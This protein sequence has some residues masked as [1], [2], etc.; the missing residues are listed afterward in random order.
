MVP[1]P[2]I[3][4]FS[5]VTIPSPV[6]QMAPFALDRD[7]RGVPGTTWSLLTSLPAFGFSWISSQWDGHGSRSPERL[8]GLSSLALPQ[9]AL[10]LVN[11]P[12]NN[13]VA[14]SC[15]TRP[16]TGNPFAHFSVTK[17]NTPS[18]TCDS[19]PF[20]SL[21]SAWSFLALQKNIELWWFF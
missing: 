20:L 19:L 15:F 3:G 18:S 12:R 1:Y 7:S 5:P 14:F 6:I 8:A 16:M 9:P 13:L 21:Q 2:S 17:Y 4:T 11:W 10:C